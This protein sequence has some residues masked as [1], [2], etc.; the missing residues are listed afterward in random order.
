M[1]P[2][3]G[4]L[5]PPLKGFQ[6][7]GSA[8][9]SASSS[10]SSDRVVV[11]KLELRIPL[12]VWVGNFSHRHPELVIEAVNISGL[13]CDETV[14]E[15]E[16]YGPSVDWTDE[17]AECPNVLEVHALGASPGPGRYQIRYRRSPFVAT[18]L[19]HEV[20]VRY[21]LTI[22]GGLMECEVIAWRSTIRHLVDA[23]ADTGHEPRLVSLRRDSLRSVHII[24]TPIQRALFR[25]ALALGYFDVPRRITLTRL[26]E[27][28]SRNKSS[29]SKTLATVERRLAQFASSA[30][31]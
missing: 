30:G 14:G 20:L 8:R 2:E 31:A 24:L 25:Q 29:V 10:G 21:P 13:P 22:K 26:A 17:I 19:E 16:I 12:D 5:R 23:L 9:S 11:M 4:R 15:Y 28:V 27:K 3:S 6:G 7:L 1:T 18:T